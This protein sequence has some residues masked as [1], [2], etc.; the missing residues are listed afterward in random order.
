MAFTPPG[1]AAHGPTTPGWHPDAAPP[2][3]PYASSPP[4]EPR[5][6]W[7]DA[8]AGR[9]EVPFVFPGTERVN[10]AEVFAGPGYT[11]PRPAQSTWARISIIAAV[12]GLVPG[13][14]V[15][16]VVAGH[17]ALRETASEYVSGRGM[18]LAGLALG[19]IGVTVW[20][21]IALVWV[22]AS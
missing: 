2:T 18:A 6:P 22:I 14:S 20:A 21:L 4:P 17:L 16:A 5:G 7:A 11:S 10:P 3:Q 1:S 19:Y 12:L 9:S 15:L 8:P 13:I